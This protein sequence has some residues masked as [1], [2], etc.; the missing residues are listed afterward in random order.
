MSAAVSVIREATTTE[1]SAT[2]SENFKS[3]QGY[4][5]EAIKHYRCQPS[6]LSDMPTDME[7][8]WRKNSLPIRPVRAQKIIEWE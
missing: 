7:R 6:F 5:S 4:R 8:R 1:V 2:L 3:V